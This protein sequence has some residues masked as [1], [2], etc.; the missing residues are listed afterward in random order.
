MV[1][2]VGGT[3]GRK[4]ELSKVVREDLTG[5]DGFIIEFRTNY[6]DRQKK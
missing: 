6:V 1:N 4:E 3:L 5:L 2:N